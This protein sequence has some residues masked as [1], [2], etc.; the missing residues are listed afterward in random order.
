MRFII[1]FLLFLSSSFYIN[2]QGIPLDD[3]VGYIGKNAGTVKS[4][5]M[6]NGYQFLAKKSTDTSTVE[7]T[8]INSND[9]TFSIIISAGIHPDIVWSLS[10]MNNQKEYSK[11]I[12]YLNDN[13][14]FKDKEREKKMKYLEK[15]IKEIR[16][17]YYSD[18]L[19][20][21]E[22]VSNSI[23]NYHLVGISNYT[24]LKKLYPQH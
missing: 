15:G 2:A 21:I 4:R 24:L 6:K 1:T 18:G 8:W 11:I 16:H 14:F 5:L 20:E 3:L 19:L 12:D 17:L 23:N 10:Y 9:T 22:L 13:G 7:E